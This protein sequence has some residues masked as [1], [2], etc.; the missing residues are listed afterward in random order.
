MAA[1]AA[2]ASTKV[3]GFDALEDDALGLSHLLRC[4]ADGD[5]SG[6]TGA[7]RNKGMGCGAGQECCMA[8]KFKT[9][10]AW[11]DTKRSYSPPAL[12]KDSHHGRS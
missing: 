7:L 12:S 6:L 4:A 5:R 2:A 3:G 1:A 8:R 10:S 11:M 9:E